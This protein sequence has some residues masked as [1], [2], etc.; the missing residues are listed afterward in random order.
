MSEQFQP[1]HFSLNEQR[2]G[3]GHICAGGDRSWRQVT[4]ECAHIAGVAWNTEDVLGAEPVQLLEAA[5]H[6]TQQLLPHTYTHSAKPE[7]AIHD[8]DSTW[9]AG[10]C[11]DELVLVSIWVR[12][13]AEGRTPMFRSV[14]PHGLICGSSSVSGSGSIAG[15]GCGWGWGFIARED[16]KPRLLPRGERGL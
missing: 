6:S 1:I 13:S 5:A 16:C 3:S 7:A 8:V 15:C 2:K 12:R 14:R 11:I 9:E 10:G 4:Q